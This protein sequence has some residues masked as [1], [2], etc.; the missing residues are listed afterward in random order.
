MALPSVAPRAAAGLSAS[1]EFSSSSAVLSTGYARPSP[2]ATSAGLEGSFMRSTRRIKLSA[3]TLTGVA[4]PVP[5]PLAV[6]AVAVG[7]IVCTS[8][9]AVRNR[10]SMPA[11]TGLSCSA[12]AARCGGHSRT[13]VRGALARSPT[14]KAPRDAG[15]A[16]A[17]RA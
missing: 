4:L 13:K 6:W 3:R 11:G 17:S 14:T 5:L 9:A 1:L 12:R 10:R 16:P 15:R 2:V 7:L 8:Y